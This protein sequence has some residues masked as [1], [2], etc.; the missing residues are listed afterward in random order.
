[1]RAQRGRVEL[2]DRLVL[3]MTVGLAQVGLN[4]G[5]K[6]NGVQTKKGCQYG[7]PFS[8]A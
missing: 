5:R 8:L 4:E 7:N 1:M 6:R 3:R 2:T